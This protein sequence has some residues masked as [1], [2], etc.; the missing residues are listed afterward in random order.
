MTHSN[1]PGPAPAVD[2]P[3]RSDALFQVAAVEALIEQFDLVRQK[4]RDHVQAAIA[5]E[6]DEDGVKCAV[7]VR[8]PGT[9]DTVGKVSTSV[10]QD[11]VTV[12]NREEFKAFVRGHAPSELKYETVTTVNPAYE[13][14]LLDQL[15]WVEDPDNEGE[16]IAT[17]VNE[18]KGESVTVPGVTRKK[19]NRVSSFSIR[20]RDNARI[21][22]Y[23]DGIN[24]AEVLTRGVTM[25]EAFAT[26]TG[27][28][29]EPGTGETVQGEVVPREDAA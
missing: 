17:L 29:V 16:E 22:E 24:I 23:L 11:K 10:S 5:A 7:D 26:I 2:Q 8:I 20:S 14:A 28:T 3:K 25:V 9:K 19:G 27:E 15:E 6:Y 21:M 12:T 18:A 1:P 4:L 13:K